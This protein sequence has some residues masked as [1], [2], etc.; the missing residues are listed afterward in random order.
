MHSGLLTST[1][2][3]EFYRLALLLTGNIRDVEGALSAVLVAGERRLR[4]LRDQTHRAAW[5]AARLRQYCLEPKPEPGKAPRLVRS[6]DSEAGPLAEVLQIE[7]YILAQHFQSLPEP[8]RS[9]LGLFY[10]D[11]FTV[12]QIADILEM[13]LEQLAA[14][15]ARARTQLQDSLRSQ[16]ISA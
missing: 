8:D 5:L 16:P 14:A 11:L 7:A 9:A 10:L 4:D 6:E 12:E 3:V 1:T 13:G 2:L 15:L